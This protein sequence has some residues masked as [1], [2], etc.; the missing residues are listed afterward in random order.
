MTKYT[1]E[2]KL[3][4]VAAYLN[5]T[6]G[7]KTLAKEHG[8]ER[9]AVQKW[10]ARYRV[11]G[12]EGLK[13]KFSHY[14]AE[15]KLSVLRHMWDNELSCRETAAVFDLRNHSYLT[16]WEKRYRSGG[17]QALASRRRGRPRKMPDTGK[18]LPPP[19]DD[20]LSNEAL[21]AELKYLRMENAYLK[22]LKALVQAKGAPTKR[23]QSW[24]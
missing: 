15:F 2:L 18:P 5:G 13:K 3:R 24:S 20:K 7:V 1:E 22:K 4:V 10:I 8:V 11:H 23:K 16:D 17:I 12:A 14:S 6:G 19:D 21:L 9:G